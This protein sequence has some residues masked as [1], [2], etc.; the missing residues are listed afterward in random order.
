MSSLQKNSPHPR[1]KISSLSQFLPTTAK[2][3]AELYYYYLL[4]DLRLVCLLISGSL[5]VVDIIIGLSDIVQVNY[6]FGK[7][8]P[9][10]FLFLRAHAA[11]RIRCLLGMNDPKGFYYDP[12]STDDTLKRVVLMPEKFVE[13]SKSA[14]KN[15]FKSYIAE[16]GKIIQMEELNHEEANTVLMAAS[17]PEVHTTLRQTSKNINQFPQPSKTLL[18]YPPPPQKGGISITVDDYQVLEEE[19]FLNDVILDFYLKWLLHKLPE[20]QRNK[21]HLFST[22]FY[23]RLTCKPKKMR[24]HH[25]VE[26]DPRLSAAEK[27]HARVKSWT[28]CVD[29]FDKDF[30]IIP[31]NEHAHWFLAIICFPGLRAPVHFETGEPIAPEALAAEE[32]ACS[33]KGAG[34]HKVRHE[35]I[36]IIDDGE[37][38]DRDEAEGDEDELEEDEDEDDDANSLQPSRKKSKTTEQQIPGLGGD[39]EQQQTPPAKT[40][41]A[42]TL[43]PIKQPCILIFDSL[44]GGHRARIVATLRDYLTVEHLHKRKEAR[45]FTRETMKGAVPR[46]PQQTNYTDC[47]LYTLQFTESFFD[48]PLKDYR[49]PMRSIVN[50]FDEALVA[51][52]REFIALLIKRLMDEYNPNHN[53]VLP[54]ISFSTPEEREKGGR[55]SCQAEERE[56]QHKLAQE[57]NKEKIANIKSDNKTPV[58][59]NIPL[60]GDDGACK[61]PPEETGAAME[62]NRANEASAKNSNVDKSKDSE[63]KSSEAPK[64]VPNPC[65]GESGSKKNQSTLSKVR[66]EGKIAALPSK[67]PVKSATAIIKN[68]K[69]VLGVIPSVTPFG[70]PQAEKSSVTGT[71]SSKGP[72][73]VS[74]KPLPASLA[75]IRDTY[76]FDDAK[77]DEEESNNNESINLLKERAVVAVTRTSALTTGGTVATVQMSSSMER[78]TAA[79]L[80]RLNSRVASANL[81]MNGLMTDHAN[82]S[83]EQSSGAILA[84]P[85]EDVAHLNKYPILASSLGNGRRVSET[86][87]LVSI[88]K[89]ENG[90]SSTDSTKEAVTNST[91]VKDRREKSSI[92]K[93]PIAVN[94]G[95][96]NKILVGEISGKKAVYSE[97]GTE[98]LMYLT[99]EEGGCSPADR[100]DNDSPD[101]Y[102]DA[103]L[104]PA[105]RLSD[106]DEG[107]FGRPLKGSE[108]SMDSNSTISVGTE[109]Q[110]VPPST[111]TS[112]NSLSST[113]SSTAD[114]ATTNDRNSPS[115]RPSERVTSFGRSINTP[116]RFRDLADPEETKKKKT[117]A[118]N[119]GHR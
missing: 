69:L 78:S 105:E 21:V 77:D 96:L 73:I 107:V 18:I 19:S 45:A 23:K 68:K 86:K 54:E 26:D 2:L 41:S 88:A 37:W 103:D 34:R 99:P 109:E 76:T 87:N 115:S 111:H 25:P 31:I 114:C 65:D 15:I 7:S 35:Q 60:L 4:F 74:Y 116:K 55:A 36:P 92:V 83:S 42:C 71:T 112:R 82:S 108:G 57:K 20:E 39:E 5:Q 56:R 89:D 29:I 104:A 106:E 59:E 95:H 50:W 98:V 11:S 80:A 97:D 63:N 33:K 38:S 28:K 10:L 51:G 1:W 13:E 3:C 100:E 12:C 43:P 70:S 91:H 40:K 72:A 90:V 102:G 75:S 94:N 64:D 27:R 84:P 85:Q 48:L 62:N 32:A 101:M 110:T 49:F 16:D 113:D 14:I 22:F 119:S 30:I 79:T 81:S 47:G 66:S 44:S 93:E 24:R 6:H 17:G 117:K 9:V 118:Q 8:M 46:V 61:Q 53:I 58:T 67:D 52:K